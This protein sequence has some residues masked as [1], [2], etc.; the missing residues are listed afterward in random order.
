MGVYYT[1]LTVFGKLKQKAPFK[2]LE[3]S[4]SNN[5]NITV[6]GND[7]KTKT[8][9]PQRNFPNFTAKFPLK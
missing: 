3:G 1:G 6:L 8:K 9:T 7:L 5:Y 4:T 2:V